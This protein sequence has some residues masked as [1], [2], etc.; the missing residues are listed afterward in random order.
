MF[1]SYDTNFSSQ[2]DVIFFINHL[3]DFFELESCLGNHQCRFHHGKKD[4]KDK[5][6]LILEDLLLKGIRRIHVYAYMSK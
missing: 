3:T 2:N 6:S 4:F 5:E 1:K